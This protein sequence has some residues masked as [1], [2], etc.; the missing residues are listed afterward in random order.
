[1]AS[2]L[3]FFI[4]YVYIYIY[5]HN[6]IVCVCI[7]SQVLLW[8]PNVKASELYQF[9]HLSIINVLFGSGILLYSKFTFVRVFMRNAG[10]GFLVLLL[11][12]ERSLVLTEGAYGDICVNRLFGCCSLWQQGFYRGTVGRRRRSWRVSLFCCDK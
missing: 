10:T 1:M 7:C 2:C 5:V 11:R 3:C 4:W 9:S 6:S 12:T 8:P